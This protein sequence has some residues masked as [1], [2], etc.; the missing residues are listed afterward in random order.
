MVVA[1]GGGAGGSF[2]KRPGVGARLAFLRT[3]ERLGFHA[4]KASTVP[5]SVCR[6]PSLSSLFSLTT[7]DSCP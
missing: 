7:L 1:K 2:C 3:I 4:G 6:L 5:P